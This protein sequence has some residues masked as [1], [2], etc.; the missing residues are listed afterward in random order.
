MQGFPSA[1][2]ICGFFILLFLGSSPLVSQVK[3][4]QSIVRVKAGRKIDYVGSRVCAECHH[5]IYKSFS[6]TDMGRSMSVVS[7]AVLALLPTSATIFDSK[8]NR[9]FSAFV[10]RGRLYQSEWAL[11]EQGRVVFDEIEKVKWIIGAGAN[12]I[13]GFILRGEDI[14]E[15]P[16]AY[17]SQT[18]AWALSPGYEDAD[19][20]FSRPIDATC[21][22]CHSGLPNPMPNAPGQFEYPPFD[23][24]AIGCENCH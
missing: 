16:L 7:P 3:N 13:G 22:S 12:A 11:D 10:R 21:I 5:S 20:G 17:Y 1:A 24:L 23:E 8:H 19:R 2:K 15:A 6:R 14:D 9:H 4:R 18:G